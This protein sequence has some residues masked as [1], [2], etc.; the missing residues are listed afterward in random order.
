M[1]EDIQTR[2]NNFVDKLMN[3]PDGTLQ[4][5]EAFKML[6][7]LYALR[8]DVLHEHIALAMGY[9]LKE[10][11]IY[12]VLRRSIHWRHVRPYYEDPKKRQTLIRGLEISKYFNKTP[13][14]FELDKEGADWFILEFSVTWKVG[15]M[16]A[17]KTE[18]YMPFFAKLKDL[19]AT[20]KRIDLKF[21]TIVVDPELTNL[22]S[23]LT[24]AGLEG[25]RLDTETMLR[26]IR[27]LTECTG[28]LKLKVADDQAT[29][30]SDMVESK[31]DAVESKEI[32]FP[33]VNPVEMRP[34]KSSEDTV[35]KSLL[36]WIKRTTSDFKE[37]AS[38]LSP[39]KS[40]DIDEAFRDSMVKASES[41]MVCNGKPLYHIDVGDPCVSSVDV[42][43]D[44]YW[45]RISGYSK[46]ILSASWPK[47]IFG[48]LKGIF[49]LQ[50]FTN[51]EREAFMS[52]PKVFRE[53]RL[54][55]MN[56][57]WP[58][59]V[60]GVLG[61]MSTEGKAYVRSM[62]WQA[63]SAAKDDVEVVEKVKSLPY[64]DVSCM[65]GSVDSIE[66]LIRMLSLDS[67]L[68]PVDEW[69]DD[70][71]ST[72]AEDVIRKVARGELNEVLKDISETKMYQILETV[73]QY[74]HSIIMLAAKKE[75][76]QWTLIHRGTTQSVLVIPPG[77]ILDTNNAKV[78]F[79]MLSKGTPT[80]NR[81]SNLYETEQGWCLSKF[82]T[83]DM[84]R[85]KNLEIA[86]NQAIM[87]TAS[88]VALYVRQSGAGMNTASRLARRVFCVS[89]LF[90][91]SCQQKFSGLLEATKYI[92]LTCSAHLSGAGKY[93]RSN[94]CLPLKTKMMVWFFR[95]LRRAA[96]ELAVA[97]D[98]IKFSR[99]NYTKTQESPE[100]VDEDS[101]GVKVQFPSFLVPEAVWTNYTGLLNEVNGCY[102]LF[103]KGLH[104]STHTKIKIHEETIEWMS[105]WEQTKAK[106]GSKIMEEGFS[107]RDLAGKTGP[108]EKQTFLAEAIW[109]A[110]KA[111]AKRYRVETGTIRRRI[112]NKFFNMPAWRNKKMRTSKGMFDRPKSDNTPSTFKVIDATLF[113]LEDRSVRNRSHV[114]SVKYHLDNNTENNVCMVK[115]GQR[116]LDDRGIFIGSKPL[117][118]KLSLLEN[119]LE[120]FA[121]SHP[122]EVIS[123]P[124]D[125]KSTSMANLVR[126]ALKWLSR[127]YSFRGVQ[128]GV[129]FNI[130]MKKKLYFK[131]GDATKWSA[132]DNVSKFIYMIEGLPEDIL[133]PSAKNF[134]KKI[135]V[136]LRKH[137]LYLRPEVAKVQNLECGLSALQEITVDLMKKAQARG[138]PGAVPIEGNWL[139]GN[140]NFTSSLC[141]SHLMD[142]V[143]EVVKRMWPKFGFG[144]ELFLEGCR[145][146]DDEM[147]IFGVLSPADPLNPD[148][149][150]MIQSDESFRCFT[151]PDKGLDA[152]LSCEHLLATACNIHE[153]E[154]KSNIHTDFIE[155]ISQ[156]SAYG[157][158][159]YPWI[160]DAMVVFSELPNTGLVE[161][162]LA[163]RSMVSSLVTHGAPLCI[164]ELGLQLV[165]K[166]V[167][168][169]Y[170]LRVNGVPFSEVA[171]IE[172]SFLPTALGGRSSA[173]PLLI[174]MAGP[175]AHDI[176]TLKLLTELRD[177]MP[178]SDR[179][180]YD[181]ALAA[182]MSLSPLGL[183]G[184]D[185]YQEH[186]PDDYDSRVVPFGKLHFK[187]FEPNREKHPKAH[188]E[189]YTRV[190]LKEFLQ[191]KPQY[192]FVPPNNVTDMD[193]HLHRIYTSRSFM[194]SMMQQSPRALHMRRARWMNGECVKIKSSEEE[195]T[196]LNV[197]L[198]KIS[199]FIHE[200]HTLNE[201]ELSYLRSIGQCKLAQAYS[202]VSWMQGVQMTEGNFRVRSA[203]KLV[204]RVLSPIT[205][206]SV[207]VNPPNWVCAY[208]V[209]PDADKEDLKSRAPKPGHLDDDVERVKDATAAAGL[210]LKPDDMSFL[211][212]LYA[213]LCQSHSKRVFLVHHKDTQS[214]VGIA[215]SILK[216]Q[217]SL[218]RVF[219]VTSD[220]ALDATRTILTP[221]ASTPQI[222]SEI[223]LMCEVYRWCCINDHLFDEVASPKYPRLARYLFPNMALDHGAEP[224]SL[225]E[226]LQQRVSEFAHFGLPIQKKLAVLEFGIFGT[227][228]VARNIGGSI[229]HESVEHVVRPEGEKQV[230]VEI[231]NTMSLVHLYPAGSRLI[232]DIATS[233]TES[234]DM[235]RLLLHVNNELKWYIEGQLTEH[236]NTMQWVLK[237]GHGKWR[238][239]RPGDIV[240]P[241]LRL[242]SRLRANPE[243]GK[244][245]RTEFV[246]EGKFLC[247]QVVVPGESLVITKPDSKSGNTR[248]FLDRKVKVGLIPISSSTSLWKSLVAR[249]SRPMVLNGVNI[250][251]ILERRVFGS[252]ITGDK[253]V[254][255][256]GVLEDMIKF[257]DVTNIMW[258]NFVNKIIRLFNLNIPPETVKYSEDVKVK[259]ERLA[260]ATRDLRAKEK[261]L[262]EKRMKEMEKERDRYKTIR[263]DERQV[264]NSLEKAIRASAGIN[265]E[266]DYEDEEDLNPQDEILWDENVR[267]I[268]IIGSSF[269]KFGDARTFTPFQLV[270]VTETR[271]ARSGKYTRGFIADLAS[272][273]VTSSLNL[274]ESYGYEPIHAAAF[275]LRLSKELVLTSTEWSTNLP[276]YPE[277][278]YI[279]SVRAALGESMIKAVPV[280]VDEWRRRK[281]EELEAE[282]VK[283]LRMPLEELKPY[284]GI[285]T[286]HLLEICQ[287]VFPSRV[288]MVDAT[289][290]RSMKIFPFL[291]QGTALPDDTGA[292]VERNY[293]SYREAIEEE[294]R[295]KLAEKR[296]RFTMELPKI[297]RPVK[298][299]ENVDK[300]GVREEG[301]DI[302]VPA[303]VKVA[304]PEIES[305][306]LSTNEDVSTFEEFVSEE[307]SESELTL[308][309]SGLDKESYLKA[310]GL[311][312]DEDLMDMTEEE[313]LEFERELDM[314]NERFMGAGYEQHPS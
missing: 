137:W 274:E 286:G 72:R 55:S 198:Q 239:S 135:I 187:V 236:P 263:P 123:I 312:E 293:K 45:R 301:P 173:G 54:G 84:N 73:R 74:A 185:D 246:Q 81:D 5:Y 106:L 212:T 230:V 298:L 296:K 207:L 313:L 202:W 43:S 136:S 294:E 40:D 249:D 292:R 35:Y 97:K 211:T 105:K 66:S 235:D 270:T 311:D 98:S 103:P 153:S 184:G 29:Q 145:H 233:I 182:F 132:G 9:P 228:T 272:Y 247:V 267:G 30:F 176:L 265:L 27:L 160:K 101:V 2:V 129:K 251:P 189:C 177:I 307:A 109:L 114:D 242:D 71:R 16:K 193:R 146:S 19:I 297:H 150:R 178:K 36:K 257:A 48:M 234:Q 1:A 159:I 144:E 304:A 121:K 222:R 244:V 6:D 252:L 221:I 88:W 223:G 8:H 216:H 302:S 68:D 255:P 192:Y 241:F 289:H 147:T 284:T 218:N 77:Q 281:P 162:K 65:R 259:Q 199:N 171:N 226:L 111:S 60:G 308:G 96:T 23:E 34:M 295:I 140:L 64:W 300:S 188:A 165:E 85:L 213:A 266:E 99:I 57:P 138:H 306:V 196:T 133:T 107:I 24:A 170:N 271:L 10:R 314:E 279:Y 175:S 102:F 37:P 143:W 104:G 273:L 283:A 120:S 51:A 158:Q 229:A 130:P 167:D 149:I 278:S 282:Y 92:A 59:C 180:T 250:T 46:E 256:L 47:Q 243:R 78:G 126:N 275:W 164:A 254:L 53:K 38:P 49:R 169:R 200:H 125:H 280:S 231:G 110:S 26:L 91:M 141:A 287:K 83:L 56:V 124:G 18:K 17:K 13:D 232:G 262:L 219:E 44:E 186:D 112:S 299:V 172:K 42:N 15:E 217:T 82:M 224:I 310:L 139:Q 14:V 63:K 152:M 7:T 127:P 303:S 206:D 131:S 269:E 3:T 21:H 52:K 39:V 148:W 25:L 31:F 75:S 33:E 76:K 41:Y 210:V 87:M 238:K 261:F 113:E 151:F 191:E 70:R 166:Y 12:N 290:F 197:V 155:F 209:C 201:K 89:S 204:P 225:Y 4:A 134:L 117:R 237:D 67:G 285:P 116:S 194:L 11:T 227:D 277:S 108:F 203:L 174:A 309:A 163:A 79:F 168:G 240:L 183:Q 61:A 80:Y 50:T 260:A 86:L 20:R 115:K 264:A 142:L 268:D 190:H 253:C 245:L 22:N 90:K 32:R 288:I 69:F 161:D 248:R 119:T 58:N 95:E 291:T 215:K 305:D 220:S 179:P 157:E 93:I 258:A 118:D 154:K 276:V 156:M 208:L 100:E 128:K 205:A 195:F 181:R 28:A 62:G 94:L 122:V 214:P